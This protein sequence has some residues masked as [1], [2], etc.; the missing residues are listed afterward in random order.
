MWIPARFQDLGSVNTK[1]LVAAIKKQPQSLWD[2]DEELKQKLAGNRETQ[3]LFLQAI[4]A[5]E[6]VDIIKQRK[7]N[8]NDVPTYSSWKYLHKE[9]QPLVDY[10]LG[11]FPKGGIV[12]RIQIARMMPGAK[13]P[14]HVDLSPLLTSSYRLHIPLITNDDV[15]FVIDGERI[16]MQEGQLYNLNNRV[17]HWVENRSDKARS[18]LIIDYLPPENNTADILKPNFDLIL[19]KRASKVDN[20][21]NS[22]TSTQT[23]LL[24]KVIATS[25]IRGANQ[26][27]SHGGIYLVDLNSGEFEQVIDWNTCD[28]DFGGRGWDRGLRGICFYNSNTY[29]ASSNEIF[30]FDK[31]FNII[32]SY[33]N[34]YLKHAHEMVIKEDSLLITSTGFDSVLRFNLKEKTFDHAWLIRLASNGKIDINQYDPMDHYGPEPANTTHLNN[35]FHDETGIYTSGRLIPYFLKLTESSVEVVCEI[36]LGTH[37]TQR[38]KDGILYND[39]ESDC[40]VFT[41]TYEYYE[42]EIPTYADEDIIHTESKDE[43]LA[44]Q[45]FGRGLCTL[46]DNIVIAGS[47][48]STISAYDMKSKSIIKSINISMDIRNA[49]HGLEVW[50]FNEE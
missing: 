9:V 23:T 19:K 28:I 32:A 30:C 45:A 46:Q 4:A 8:Q 38:Y 16:K 26:N 14:Q 13:I 49:I 25:V 29:I 5:N 41:S 48:P 20:Q 47:S 21:S 31:T 33:K 3:S 34:P 22:Q 35:V 6:F 18:H 50:P 7:I 40:I 24:P 12:L 2:A 44:R 42:M 39:T 43:K 15:Y 17:P 36:P 11:Q 1:E 37:N 27:E 10:A